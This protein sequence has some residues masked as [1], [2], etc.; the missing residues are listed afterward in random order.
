MLIAMPTVVVDPRIRIRRVARVVV[1]SVLDHRP[2][3]VDSAAGS[4]PQGVSSRV[5][6][7]RDP[8]VI[9]CPVEAWRAH[10][11]AVPNY[12]KNAITVKK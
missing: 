12:R 11:R 9:V 10:T 7:G 5:L 1:V 4:S 8:N 6:D 2:R 3:V